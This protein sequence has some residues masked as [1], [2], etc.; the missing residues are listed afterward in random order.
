MMLMEK[1]AKPKVLI[2]D[3]DEFLLDMYSTKFK[4]VGFDVEFASSASEALN[5]MR[6]NIIPK[7]ILLDI[8]MPGMDGFEFLSIFNQENLAPDSRII[9]LSNLGQKDHFDKALSLGADDYI[10]KAYFTPSELV[11]KTEAILKKAPKAVIKKKK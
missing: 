7:V 1:K 11:K 2:I 4:E 10:V 5:K 9:V 8:V 6:N 3:D